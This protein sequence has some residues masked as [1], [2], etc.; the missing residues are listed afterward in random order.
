MKATGTYVT[1]A[2]AG[3]S[4]RAFVPNPLPPDPP[5]TL[6]DR[7]HDLIEKANRALGRLDG[8]T[9]LLP[10]VSLFL[11]FYVRKEAVLSSQIEGTQSS[12]S[13][14]LLHE[15]DLAPG[16]PLDDVQEVSNYVAAMNHG[17]KRLREDN[18][19]LSLRL[20]REVHQVLLAAGRGS[21][22]TPGEFR[23]SQNWLGGTRPGNARFVPPPPDRVAACMN[24]LE[25]FLHDQ[26]QRTP[27]LVKAALAHVQFETIHPFLDGNGRLGRLLITLILCA[28]DVLTQP[29]LYLSL[30]FKQHR[31]EYYD[32]LDAVRLK[33]DWLGWL[34][35]FLEGVQ[36]TARQATDTAGLILRLFDEDRRKVEDLGRRAGS[37][38]R[39]LD[40]LRRHPITTIPNAAAQLHLTAPTVRSAVESLETLGIVREITGKQ[41]D[42]IYLYDQ[43]VR[44]LDKGTE[45][46]PR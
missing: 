11:Y 1:T 8:I 16:V 37:A 41:R 9:T 28:E 45:P 32:R 7:D 33:G 42:R 21:D 29:L 26:P 2:T 24:D 15:E 30:F 14:L 6:T 36:H 23:R 46:L 22:K 35:F 39:V 43:Y 25:K 17:L 44:I 3:E 4:V 19:P 38:R 31:Q 20:I 13:D 18:F 34:R 12:F 10:D 40:Q 5:V 27:T